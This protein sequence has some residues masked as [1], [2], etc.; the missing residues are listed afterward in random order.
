MD[1]Q[2][3]KENLQP[4]REDFVVGKFGDRQEAEIAAKFL[5]EANF[6]VEQ[7]QI[8]TLPLK[9]LLE[10]PESPKSN[11]VKEGTAAAILGAALG[12]TIGLSL[13]L[14][15]GSLPDAN[16][17]I[18][19]SPLL[20]V[21]ISGV[22]GALSLGLIGAIST[23]QFPKTDTKIDEDSTSFDYGLIIT[24]KEEDLDRA[25]QILRQQGMQV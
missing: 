5:K 18:D 24:G 20:I 7:I 17:S 23:G 13:N 19:L 16:L 8:K 12:I 2:E 25:K 9:E 6:P 1:R 21:I 15:V 10:L 14:I 3:I 22:L 11:E 4:A